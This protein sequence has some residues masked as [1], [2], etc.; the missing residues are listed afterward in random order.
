MPSPQTAADPWQQYADKP[1]AAVGSGDPWA[2]YAEKP[3]AGQPDAQPAQQ[4]S[5]MQVLTQ[6]TEKTD[7]EYLGYKGPAG[8]AGA[9]VH[10]FSNVANETENAVAGMGHAILHPIDT[11][12][13]LGQ[14]VMAAPS[15][16]GQVP[17][18]IHDINQSADPLGTYAK[19]AEDTADQGAGQLGVMAATEGMP[20]AMRT[21]AQPSVAAAPVRVAARA[22][23]G[24][25]NSA[26]LRYA[27]SVVRMFT[28]ADEARAM[29]K[30][31][32]RDLGLTK[33]VYPGVTLPERP[34][35]VLMQARGLARGGQAGFEP[36]EAL[37]RLPV[38]AAEP[39]AIT[40]RPPGKMG[41]RLILTPEEV[42]AVEQ[43]QKIA[44]K[45]ASERGM[46]Y[47]AGMKPSGAKIAAP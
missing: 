39:Q 1:P 18:A 20:A 6:P 15:A 3:A 5:V 21:I 16:I 35:P 10:G 38:H 33:P 17:G 29:I 23:E 11:A 40:I 41:G 24:V 13:S 19:A 22:A 45:R 27:R 30:V 28:P 14:A 46:Q 26:P 47:A 12:R 36:S 43:I 31:P 7:Q 25:A 4:P 2:Q 8:V 9:T 34:L 37:D 32:G 42:N 44:T